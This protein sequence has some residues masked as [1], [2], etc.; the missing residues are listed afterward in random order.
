MAAQLPNQRH[1]GGFLNPRETLD[2]PLCPP[3][4]E[5][6]DGRRIHRLLCCGAVVVSFDNLPC[7]ANCWQRVTDGDAQSVAG[8]FACLT[9][10]QH[11]VSL[12]HTSTVA[13]AAVLRDHGTEMDQ[14]AVQRAAKELLETKDNIY[15]TIKN[16]RVCVKADANPRHDRWNRWMIPKLQ[17]SERFA[18]PDGLSTMICTSRCNRCSS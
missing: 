14:R 5:S 18:R 11:K 7:E 15:N 4:G 8:H 16:G 17:V 10:I 13:F 2:F 12:L 3:V 6:E 1:V 9:C